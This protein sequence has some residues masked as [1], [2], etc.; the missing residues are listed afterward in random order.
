MLAISVGSGGFITDY[1]VADSASPGANAKRTPVSGKFTS[2]SGSS[3]AKYILGIDA[4]IGFSYWPLASIGSKVTPAEAKYGQA[5][6]LWR[7]G[8]HEI[9][10]IGPSNQFWFCNVERNTP[11]GCGTTAFSSVPAGASL[12]MF[13]ADGAAV[14]LAVLLNQA[15]PAGAPGQASY[16]LVRFGS[17]PKSTS[18]DR[19]VFQDSNGLRASVRLR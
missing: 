9:G 11:L 2:M 16:T 4:D 15:P 13:R 18:G 8:T 12:R 1:I 5:G 19:V 7:P 14:L 6:A 17:D 10:F 3:D